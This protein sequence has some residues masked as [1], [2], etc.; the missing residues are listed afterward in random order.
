MWEAGVIAEGNGS[1]DKVR[2]YAATRAADG[3]AGGSV[4]LLEE[5]ECVV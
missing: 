1:S 4:D 5:V 3:A 2:G